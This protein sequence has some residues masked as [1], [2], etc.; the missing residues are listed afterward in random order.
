MNI[1]EEKGAVLW[2]LDITGWDEYSAEQLLEFLE[3]RGFPD[4]LRKIFDEK[5]DEYRNQKKYTKD[6]YI[7]I[8]GEVWGRGFEGYLVSKLNEECDLFMEENYDKRI[9]SST[10][11]LVDL[12]KKNSYE[13]IFISHS[14]SEIVYRVAQRLGMDAAFGI[15]LG[16][17]NGVF[18]GTIANT[19]HHEKGKGKYTNIIK[20]SGKYNWNKSIS[21]F[22]SRA[23][24]PMAERVKFPIVLNPTDGIEEIA[25]QRGWP[26][27]N[28]D[29]IVDYVKNEFNLN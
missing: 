14:A 29:T 26:I 4:T 13:N 3:K 12:F 23:D 17:S 25:N 21:L 9:L 5:T 28:N 19:L 2:D 20:D 11:I 7:Q 22:D 15:V 10:P 6:Q 16:R 18:D 27:H 8:F 24:I 1:K